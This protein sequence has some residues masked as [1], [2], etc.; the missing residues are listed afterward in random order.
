M[1]VKLDRKGKRLLANCSDRIIRWA[2]VGSPP[3]QDLPAG[4]SAEESLA[5]ARMPAK[6]LLPH[7][8]TKSVYVSASLK[9][10]Q[11]VSDSRL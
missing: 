2:M 10:L 8:L 11:L 5:R 1:S 4:F 6:V 7:H 9:L 3:A